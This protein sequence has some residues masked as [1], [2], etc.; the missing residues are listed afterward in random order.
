MPFSVAAAI[1]KSG[2]INA[3]ILVRVCQGTKAL[4]EPAEVPAVLCPAA[5][6]ACVALVDIPADKAN[7]IAAASQT[8]CLQA[9][10]TPCQ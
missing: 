2:A 4:V 6:E 9:M 3:G 1:V 10:N 8:L 7:A 5:D